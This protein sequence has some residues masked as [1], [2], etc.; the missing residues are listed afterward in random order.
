MDKL[1]E[2][3]LHKLFCQLASTITEEDLKKENYEKMEFRFWRFLDDHGIAQEEFDAYTELR[4]HRSR[5]N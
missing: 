5:R 2:E 4:R 1:R 3:E